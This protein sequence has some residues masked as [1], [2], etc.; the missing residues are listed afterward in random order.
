MIKLLLCANSRFW[1]RNLKPGLL[2][3]D[4]V[5]SQFLGQILS[6]LN[7]LPHALATDAQPRTAN[8]VNQ[9]LRDFTIPF[10]GTYLLTYCRNCNVCL[11]WGGLFAPPDRWQQQCVTFKSDGF[12]WM[13]A[14]TIAWFCVFFVTSL[15]NS[16]QECA[17]NCKWLVCLSILD[18]PTPIDQHKK[19][20]WDWWWLL[21]AIT[22]P[23]TQPRKCL[24][25]IK[26]DQNVLFADQMV[27]ILPALTGGE[28]LCVMI[29]SIS[30]ER[31]SL[32]L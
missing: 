8:P 23:K 25:Y 17:G 32:G 29:S 10:G 6:S 7:V 19:F 3:T 9:P 15:G 20:N 31:L 21:K 26:S 18:I 1:C 2:N 12:V 30:A 28:W 22:I 27:V 5:F 4:Y 11:V 14:S 16:V 24:C 13:F